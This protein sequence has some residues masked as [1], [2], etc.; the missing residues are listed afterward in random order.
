MVRLSSNRN[1]N[2]NRNRNPNQRES[3]ASELRGEEKNGKGR[4]EVEYGALTAGHLRFHDISPYSL[5][6]FCHSTVPSSLSLFPIPISM[7]L[8]LLFTSSVTL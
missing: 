8:L 1:R 2:R 4:F 3:R 7:T 6:S 5:S